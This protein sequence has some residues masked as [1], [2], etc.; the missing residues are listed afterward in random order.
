MRNL[1]IVFVLF[2][3]CSGFA[4]EIKIE[5]KVRDANTYFAIQMVNIYVKDSKEGTTSGSDGTFKL[6]INNPTENTILIFEHIAFDTLF[7][8]LPDALEMDDF[9]LQPRIIQFPK[10]TIEAQKEQPDIAKDLPQAIAIVDAKRFEVQGYVDAGDLLKTEQSVQIDENISGEKNI[11]IRAGNAEDV[12]ILYNGIKMNDVYDNRFDLSLI[13]LEDIRQVQIIKG[14]NTALYGS[15]AF[16]GVVNF[17][18]KTHRNYLIRFM[19]RFGS[20]NSG[21]FNLQLN[22]YF[23]NRLNISYN[24][25]KCANNRRYADSPTDNFHLE[26]KLTYHTGN[27]VYNFSD[28]PETQLTDQFSGSFIYSKTSFDDQR[29]NESIKNLNRAFSIRFEGDIAMIRDLNLI[30]SKQLLDKE[31]NLDFTGGYHNRLFKNDRSYLNVEKNFDF[32]KF[33]LLAAYQYEIA[34]LDYSD[35]INPSAEPQ[36]GVESG[37]FKQIRHGFVSILKIQTPTTASSMQTANLDISYRYDDVSNTSEKVVF[38]DPEFVEDNIANNNWSHSTVKFSAHLSGN[39]EI[40][41]YTTFLNYGTNI[42]FPTLFQQLSVPGVADPTT[43]GVNTNLN[44]EKN[45]SLE[46][47]LEL[48]R[49]FANPGNMDGWLLSGTYFKN[50]Y[51]NKFRTYTKPGIPVSFYEN[52]PTAD[53]SGFEGRVAGYFLRNKLTLEFAI[54]DYSISDKAAFPFKYDSKLIANI[55]IDHAGYSFQVHWFYESEQIGLIIDN[56][57]PEYVRQG[58]VLPEYQNLDIHFGKIFEV[59]QF[60]LFANFTVRNLLNTEFDLAGIAIRDRRF[61]ISLGFEY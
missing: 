25:K 54:S 48:K 16:S 24:F 3:V 6:I 41:E 43:P 58:L 36:P 12:I 13:N 19:Q 15:E 32:G 2:I 5:G 47:G 34:D 37:L 21:D 53:I 60:K 33:D 44:P 28:K 46:I 49:E 22:H 26:N 42:K 20:Y 56:D 29:N 55:L 30:A 35:K 61:Y 4:R 18:P 11:S 38:R 39:H 7:V 40:S 27:I 9:Y 57:D 50:Y 23:F 31:E 14:S 8:E 51:E 52:V 10:I 45:R 1:L 59:W 17:I